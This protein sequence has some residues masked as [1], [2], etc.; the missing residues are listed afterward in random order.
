MTSRNNFRFYVRCL[1][2]FICSNT[3]NRITSFALSSICKFNGTYLSRGLN[4]WRMKKCL[5]STQ[6]RVWVQL[7]QHPQ[8]LIRSLDSA[9]NNLAISTKVRFFFSVTSFCCGVQ[10]IVKCLTVRYSSYNCLK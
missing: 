10:G 3:P 9:I 8:S 7:Q 5:R 4:I 1:R 6:L 2:T